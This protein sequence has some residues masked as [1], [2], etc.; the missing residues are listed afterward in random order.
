MR[1]ALFP[2]LC[3]IISGLFIRTIP[4][5]AQVH[6][7]TSA[8][9]WQIVADHDP[10]LVLAYG[11]SPV[12]P[13][14]LPAPMAYMME[15]YAAALAADN[16]QQET[17]GGQLS[18]INRQLSAKRKANF[19]DIAPMIQTHWAQD[20]P[21]NNLCP[22]HPGSGGKICLTGC[23][24]TAMAQVLY[25]YQLPKTMSGYKTYGLTI[26]TQRVQNSFDFASTHLD[27]ANMLPS[28]TASST[29]QQQQAVA[30]L[31]R[32]CGI[33]A[34]MIYSYKL[35][36]ADPAIGADGINAFFDG[37][38]AEIRSVDVNTILSELQAGRPVIYSGSNSAQAHCFVIDGSNRQG[39]LHCNLG[40]GGQGDGDYLPTNLG[41]YPNAQNLM[42]ISPTSGRR[43]CTPMSELRGKYAT[44]SAV[45]AATLEA[46]RWYI[47]WNSGRAGSP[48]SS[49]VGKTITSTGNIPSAYGEPTTENA[50]QLVRF[51]PKSGG[52]YYIQTGLGDYWGSFAPNGGTG[53]TTSGQSYAFTVGT[54]KSTYFWLRSTSAYIDTNGIGKT[55]VGWGTT[56]PTD[57]LSNSAWRLFPVTITDGSI[58]ANF[59]PK[60]EYTI[61]NT[62]YSQGYLVATG[63]NDAHP[64][65]RGV[66]QDHANGLYQGAAYH[67]PAD[68]SSAGARWKI[69]SSEGKQYLYNQLT[70]KYLTNTGDRTCYIFTDTPTPI[71][72]N[73]IG[74]AKY[75][76]NAGS[77]AESYLCAA[78]N[79][80]NPA[81]F[82]TADDTGSEWTI[83]PAVDYT[84]VQSIS[85][86]A[87]SLTMMQGSTTQLSVNF[88]PASADNKGIRWESSEPAIVSVSDAGLLTALAQGS[89]TITATSADNPSVSATCQVKV[90]QSQKVTG[91]KLSLR[92]TA[93]YMLRTQ[94]SHDGY[95]VG[96]A[97]ETNHPTLRGVA[98]DTWS[99]SD[100]YHEAV[101]F[102][103]PCAQWQIILSSYDS[104]KDVYLAYIYNPGLG[105]YLTDGG[106]SGTPFV[107]TT[108]PTEL[109]VLG[110]SDTFLFRHS[111]S[112]QQKPSYLMAAPQQENPAYY[113]QSNVAATTWWLY[114]VG[115]GELPT[116]V[117]PITPGEAA[118]GLSQSM[119][120][121]QPV[122]NL[123]GARVIGG[124]SAKGIYISRGCKII[125]R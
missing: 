17:D 119:A 42:L 97:G 72:I 100:K 56:V 113:G 43:Q 57:T 93:L 67:D 50:C 117:A 49:G 66:Q 106:A 34:S 111:A 38:K 8:E 118:S 68:L 76:L 79:L 53:V 104:Q 7:Q 45:P 39:Y 9:G 92:P 96:V 86:S 3:L 84:P 13:D 88:T 61:R 121:D 28:Y 5:Y 98:A 99:Y 60:V 124:A 110:S 58:S 11:T 90:G 31:M 48:F 25:Y 35:S 33:A 6:L 116:G 108:T 85:L 101:D 20:A 46:N 15:Q 112:T 10:G 103:S 27:W 59:D 107:Y 52:G 120:A 115:E 26:G 30:T 63:A 23:V 37:V 89:A 62:G 71:Y 75:T 41:G 123:Q 55:T 65:L 102:S 74:G 87:S 32:A 1:I 4:T 18:T 22:E 83:E 16:R 122:Y 95:L 64:T 80:E 19:T 82:W 40:W 109:T 73:N 78:T 24:A 94:V 125:L 91:G 70:H 47:L 36:T 44:A 29:Q 54:I 21:Y 2:L 14:N 105:L 69:T 51:V 12:D 81:A 77:Q 114:E